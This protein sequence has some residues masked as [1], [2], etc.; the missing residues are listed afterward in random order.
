MAGVG[1]HALYRSQL[2]VSA[3]ATLDGLVALEIKRRVEIDAIV[4]VDVD[5]TAIAGNVEGIHFV[6]EHQ[7][8]GLLGA[9]ARAQVGMPYFN[10][11]KPRPDEEFELGVAFRGVAGDGHRNVEGD[12]EL[13]DL[14]TGVG[15]RVRA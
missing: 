2:G 15:V 3:Q 8:F 1:A 12:G 9:V 4:R 13:Y 14:A 10:I 7:L 5:D 6:G 11:P